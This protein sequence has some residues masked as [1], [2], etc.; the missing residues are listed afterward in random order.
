M[1][2]LLFLFPFIL[3]VQIQAAIIYV[4]HS[5]TGMNNGTSWANAYTDLETA[6]L[7][8]MSGDEIWVAKGTYFT[9]L[10]ND[11][12]SSFVLNNG[13]KLYGN[14]L[15]NET[16]INQ[17]VDLIPDASGSNRTNETI[18]SGDIG[19][20]NDSTDNAG[21]VMYI[22][23]NTLPIIIDGVKV[24]GGNAILTVGKG[25]GG[26]IYI[27]NAGSVFLNNII[28][29]HNTGSAG[30]DGKGSGIYIENATSFSIN[31][32]SIVNNFLIDDPLVSGNAIYLG[33]GIYI[34]CPQ[35]QISNCF[36][37]NNKIQSNRSSSEGGGLYIINNLNL[38]IFNTS[39]INNSVISTGTSS[40]KYLKG[41][42]I[43][44][45]GNVASIIDLNSV[46]ISLNSI[47]TSRGEARG[48][49][50]YLSSDTLKITSCIV[51][52]NSINSNY[53]VTA[54]NTQGCGMYATVEDKTS[55]SETE[56]NNNSIYART[57]SGGGL[58]IISSS[59]DTASIQNCQFSNNSLNS[60]SFY[61]GTLSG[62]GLFLGLKVKLV[63]CQI[64]NNNVIISATAT[65]AYSSG[66]ANAY[67]GG[68]YTSNFTE[69]L[70]CNI[71]SN[72]LESGLD[73]NVEN[74][75]TFPNMTCRAFGGGL[76]ASSKIK[77]TL[78]TINN[79]SAI[80]S[81][82]SYYS[83]SQY[84]KGYSYGGGI[85]NE[86]TTTG[87]KSLIS[88]CSISN[89]ILD[90]YS[91]LAYSE[92]KGGG[93]YSRNMDIINNEI[94]NNDTYASLSVS[95]GLNQGGGIYHEGKGNLYFNTISNNDASAG[96]Y[97]MSGGYTTNTYGGGLYSNSTDS[98]SNC[99]LIHNSV[100]ARNKSYGGGI[101]NVGTSKISNITLALN[102]S[103]SEL[104]DR[105]GSGMFTNNSNAQI[106]NSIIYFNDTLNYYD[107]TTTSLVKNSIIQLYQSGNTNFNINPQFADT[108]ALDFHVLSSSI[109]IDRGDSTYIPIDIFNDLDGNDRVSGANVDIG[110]YE[111][112]LC[113]S[114]T[115]LNVA[116]CEG[117]SFFFNEENLI[118]SGIYFDTLINAAGCD[119]LVT[120]NLTVNHNNTGTDVI[121]AC[122]SY[123]WIDGITYTSS[124]NTATH[125]LQNAAGCDSLVTL[126]LTVNHNNTGTDVIT[127]CDSYTWIDGI[128][129]TSSNN[130][131]THTLQNVAGCDSLVT[132]NLTVNHSN[133]GTD[134][135]TACDSYTWI[136][137]ITYTS[138]NN[139]A[140]HTLQNAA[141]CD[142]L[143][144]LNLTINHSN[145]GTD[146]ITACDSYTW[147]DGITYTSSNNT[148]THTLQ[149]AA[150][151]DSLVTL[152]LTINHSNT[153]TDVITAC[154]S[155]T[156]IDGITY[157]SS[158]NTATHTLQNVAGCD[159]L[160]TLNL[161]V[162]HSNTGTDVITACDSYTWIDG[163]TYT[164][165][166][167]S[168]THTLQ[169]AAGC[170]SLVT[171]NLTIN[172]SNTGTDVITACDS[173]TWIDGITY[174]SSN[175][176][177]T[178]TLQNA[179]GCDSLVT[180]NLTINHN[181]TGT[182]VITA[183]DSYTWIH[184]ITYTSSNNT[185]THTLQNAS[186]CDSLITLN[187]TVNHSNTGTDVITACDSYTWIDGITYTSS[188]NTATHT[189]QNAA[190]CDSLVTL[191]LDITDI[192]TNVT[193]NG[194]TL[195]ANHFGA[196]YQWVD[197]NNAYQSIA[198][199]IS[200]SF[201]AAAN[202]YYAVIIYEGNCSDTSAC[203][204][205][206]TVELQNHIQKNSI[207]INPN[208]NNG[209]FTIELSYPALIE[210]I[211]AL[212]RLVYTNNHNEGI[213]DISI[214]NSE[215]GIYYMRAI[216]D[217]NLIIS[218][219][220]VNK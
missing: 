47:T 124:N 59:T 199:E 206:T 94:I 76:Y 61:D 36:V 140:T 78:S 183:C 16:N 143:I 89:N 188:N 43:A 144:T 187:L 63:N 1:K 85:Y 39:I 40:I 48:A 133:T 17:R 149:N 91:S 168:A 71:D 92:T 79:N 146:V 24:T 86:F 162:N 161:T 170:D 217:N 38:G 184:G 182:D 130:S 197:C 127:A 167:N 129:Y 169:N 145:T 200:Q 18:L 19:V 205:I 62:G 156:W 35:N 136:D 213:F 70:N 93:I 34:N 121:T 104:S 219:I 98:I 112:D 172:H 189:L 123:T 165:S 194:L 131:A 101:Y 134:V 179:S 214:Q 84:F 139:T 12:N 3:A 147:I 67:G 96:T 8:A 164:S 174:T 100:T 52:Q 81:I 152:N 211:D 80:S 50:S 150:G 198:N 115:T 110:T 196:T 82:S 216:S 202:G 26:G 103:I 75:M 171:L 32:S 57:T 102:H 30:L 186:G 106:L 151:C 109:A 212:G 153:G 105:K 154:D 215:N 58:Y 148:A 207:S 126:N 201:I 108:S 49:G 159:S 20:L 45:S 185:A 74:Y 181:S 54:Y 55:I 69:L 204:Y 138:S 155:Y 178:H 137:G 28:V 9:S 4:N 107:Q 37:E 88:N 118:S 157:T 191:N 177:A 95:G 97:Y 10:S 23:G 90:S 120:L 113:K 128:T 180:L 72:Y 46:D 27:E 218:R 125:T 22:V 210:I 122:D 21:H 77:L 42:G 163:I 173:Y 15:G 208:P 99:L 192:N 220:L 64:K 41:G 44:C 53:T 132:L 14:F 25:K 65:S 87:Q 175:N 117:N 31:N 176:T 114:Y 2:K 56:F 29:S 60:L 73:Y 190:G 142:S 111:L 135:I 33:G 193:V 141:G 116:I 195:T 158:N 203:E 5:A 209:N 68:I 160:I 166:N 11:R 6:M 13:V 119:S 83:W 51:N 7:F 66:T